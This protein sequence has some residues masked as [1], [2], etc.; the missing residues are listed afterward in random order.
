M[1]A[2]RHPRG[3]A[4]AAGLAE[5]TVRPA[6]R[7]DRRA[8]ESGSSADSDLVSVLERRAAETPDFIVYHALSDDLEIAERIDFAGLQLRARA[9]AVTLDRW[10]QRGDRVLLLFPAGIDFST[11]F[12]GCLYSGRLAVPLPPPSASRLYETAER[13][14]AIAAVAEPAVAIT[15]HALLNKLAEYFDS[16]PAL[17][18]FRWLAVEDVADADAA[19]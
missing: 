2:V 7:A 11:A 8:H 17:G 16:E 19:S 12:M 1:S 15:T 14:L 9:V 18:R 5:D 4:A 10:S 3:E 6:A 13:L